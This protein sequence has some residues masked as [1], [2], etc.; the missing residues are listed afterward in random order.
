MGQSPVSDLGT[1]SLLLFW[2]IPAIQ[3]QSW[4]SR[5]QRLPG[6]R[7]FTGWHH[8]LAG[9]SFPICPGLLSGDTTFV[10]GWRQG[11]PEVCRPGQGPHWAEVRPTLNSVW[12]RGPCRVSRTPGC[13]ESRPARYSAPTSA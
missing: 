4:A 10:E 9:R 11:L 5:R 2:P 7:S 12:K 3:V 1:R 13:P 8:F 6:F